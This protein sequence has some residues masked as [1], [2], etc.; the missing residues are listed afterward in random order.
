MCHFNMVKNGNSTGLGNIIDLRQQFE[1]FFIV[2][3]TFIFQETYE[4]LHQAVHQT[5][6]YTVLF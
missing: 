3:N 5:C 4:I 2:K 6:Q 1:K